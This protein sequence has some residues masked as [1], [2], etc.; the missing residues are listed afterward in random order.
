MPPAPVIEASRR[1]SWIARAAWAFA[2]IL[3]LYLA[4]AYLVIPALWARHERQ[5]ELAARPMVT[6]TAQGIPGDPLNVGLV[7]SREEI[8]RAM[9]RAAWHPADPITLRT[10]IEIGE[11]VVLHRSYPDAPVSSLFYEGRRQDLAFEMAV[12]RSPAHRHHVRFWRTLAS[13]AEGREVW[14]GAA[15][16]DRSVGISHDTG[17]ITHHIGPDL[18]AERAFVMASLVEAGALAD[19]YRILGIGPTLTGRNGGGDPYYTDGEIVVGVLRP[20]LDGD[21]SRPQPVLPPSPRSLRDRVW[22][23]VVATGRTIGLLPAPT[24]PPR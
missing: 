13:G 5:P 7:G 20:K 16:Y 18:D 24:L 22:A 6:V 15:S 4:A 17:Q 3:A 21:T 14:L 23:A 8:V 9:V 19:I 1:A 10:S 11:S 2:A 12:D